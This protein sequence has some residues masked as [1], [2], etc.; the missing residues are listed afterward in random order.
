MIK[1]ILSKLQEK[2][3]KKRYQKILNDLEKFNHKFLLSDYGSCERVSWM[4]SIYKLKCINCCNTF[5]ICISIKGKENDYLSGEQI[6]LNYN[7]I[8]NDY[9]SINMN[10]NDMIVMDIIT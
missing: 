3:H 4:L 9:K 2:N 8:K 1:T 7:S 10:C 5:N 6:F